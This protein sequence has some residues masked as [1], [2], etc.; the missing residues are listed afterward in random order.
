MRKIQLLA[1]V[2]TAAAATGA[3]AQGLS[4]AT[5]TSVD[6]SNIHSNAVV[7][8]GALDATGNQAAVFGPLELFRNYPNNFN[9]ANTV[10]IFN[11]AGLTPGAGFRIDTAP[12]SN[13]NP[14]Y[15]TRL[16][17]RNSANAVLGNNDDGA[18][19]PWSRV[20][21]T[22]PGDGF[23][24]AA[25]TWWQDSSY[26]GVHSQEGWYDLNVYQASIIT[27]AQRGVNV[28]WWK[29]E[30]LSAGG[31]FVAE[32]IFA[33][34]PGSFG[35]NDT[36]IAAFNSSGAFLGTDDDGAASPGGL[37]RLVGTVPGDGIVYV[38][39]TS[40]GAGSITSATTYDNDLNTNTRS[41]PF[42]LSF[43]PTPG[44]AGLLALGGLV[45]MRRRRA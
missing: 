4:F 29:F 6:T 43:I 31:Q 42:T 36:M 25:V 44:T 28:Q 2:G 45:A 19:A 18:G 27:P 7:V 26:A 32:T 8:N 21:G 33:S 38:A 34:F 35:G 30:N 40:F 24:E 1:V 22:V 13:G 12:A 3:M 10:D 5:A 15:D 17:V 11:I 14:S 20:N 9:A 41:G 39:V 16:R 23:L 37:S